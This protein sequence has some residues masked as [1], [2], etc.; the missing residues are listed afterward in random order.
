L[1]D[2]GRQ[3]A[4]R[5]GLQIAATVAVIHRGKGR[6]AAVD[7]TSNRTPEHVGRTARQFGREAVLHACLLLREG[8][9]AEE[10]LMFGRRLRG[11]PPR[12]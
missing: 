3:E 11:G 1:S 9:E 5:L 10:L 12:K 6:G 4:L 8:V 7:R 2:A